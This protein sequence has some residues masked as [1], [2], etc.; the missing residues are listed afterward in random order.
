MKRILNSRAGI[1]TVLVVEYVLA[2]ITSWF[3]IFNNGMPWGLLRND[4]STLA[5]NVMPDLIIGLL[6]GILNIAFYVVVIVLTHIQLYKVFKNSV[7]SQQ[8]M[9]K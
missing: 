4:W 6:I 5:S 3:I 1:T 2:I 8:Q 9:E 7:Q